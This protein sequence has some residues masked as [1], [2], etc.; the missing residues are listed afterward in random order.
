M[1]LTDSKHIKCAKYIQ[2]LGR[3]KRKTRLC[4]L[5]VKQ[6]RNNT[7]CLF[8]KQ[9]WQLTDHLIEFISWDESKRI[10]ELQ[11]HVVSALLQ[12]DTLDLTGTC[13]FQNLVV[14]TKGEADMDTQRTKR[15]F[16]FLE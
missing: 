2:R 15:T 1:L 6:S 5:Y 11:S 14:S 12:W 9:F 8:S 16:Q 10:T 4:F 13:D 7:A 3:V